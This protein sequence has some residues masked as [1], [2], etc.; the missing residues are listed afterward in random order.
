MEVITDIKAYKT[1]L[2]VRFMNKKIYSIINLFQYIYNKYYFRSFALNY[3][4]FEWLDIIDNE[5][6]YKD[7]FIGV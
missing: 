3:S 4:E 2:F 7:F 1:V 6:N 5:N